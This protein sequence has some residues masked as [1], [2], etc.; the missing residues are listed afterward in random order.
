MSFVR[1][2][3]PWIVVPIV[4]LAVAVAVILMMSEGPVDKHVYP[5]R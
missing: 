3:W 4:L 1:Q 2:N 5:T